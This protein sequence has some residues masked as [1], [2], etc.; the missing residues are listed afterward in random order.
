MS[1]N[2]QNFA[3][4]QNFQ[5]DNLVDF[6]KMLQNA[7]LLAKIGADTTENE[8]IFAEILPKIGNEPAGPTP[9]S[10]L[11]RDGVVRGRPVRRPRT[12][13]RP[14]LGWAEGSAARPRPG[15][16]LRLGG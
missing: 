13:R 9:G 12:G 8:R 14:R 5:F 3:K 4:F 16:G 11:D 6:E 15:L 2:L 7:Y 1:Q 10:P